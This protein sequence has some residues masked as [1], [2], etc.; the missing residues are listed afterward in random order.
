MYGLAG[1]AMPPVGRFFPLVAD[2]APPSS[3]IRELYTA[4]ASQKRPFF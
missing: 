4:V 2:I 1:A 3:R